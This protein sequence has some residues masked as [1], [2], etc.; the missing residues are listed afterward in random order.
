VLPEKEII[1]EEL[2]FD[3]VER[4]FYDDLVSRGQQV[5]EDLQNMKGGLGRSM[6]N[7]LTMLLRLRQGIPFVSL[8]SHSHGPYRF[9]KRQSGRRQ[10][11]NK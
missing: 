2:E 1:T 6:M 9:A 11:R 7:L 5:I 4:K 3:G 8:N 10:G